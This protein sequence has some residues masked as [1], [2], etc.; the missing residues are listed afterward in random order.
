[1]RSARVRRGGRLGLVE[2][3]ARDTQQLEV[4]GGGDGPGGEARRGVG[5][6]RS[7]GLAGAM[8]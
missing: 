2:V 3:G 6:A 5:H 4:G 7:P 8:R 1:M